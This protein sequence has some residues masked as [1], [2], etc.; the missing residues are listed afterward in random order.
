MTAGPRRGEG[1]GSVSG[2]ERQREH[3]NAILNEYDAHYGDATSCEYRQRFFLA[4]LLDGLDLNDWAVADLAAGSGHTTLGLKAMFPRIRPVGFD[5]SETAVEAYISR[6]GCPAY[7]LDLTVDN[8]PG[9]QFDAVIVVGGLHHCVNAIEVALQNVAQLLRPGGLFLMVEPSRETILEPVRRAWYGRDHY[10]EASSE[11]ALAYRELSR[12][13]NAWFE[14]M[15]VRY[16]GGV[17][18]FL[19]YNSLVFR[20]PLGLKRL[21]APSLL[22]MESLTNL[23]PG[24]VLFPY[25]VARWRRRF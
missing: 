9:P 24:K 2:G 18:Y 6:T 20:V 15:L 10:F 14:P 5:V 16:M 22:A 21:L 19:I 8:Q 7:L 25:F 11:G 12:H 3:Y 23:L 4:P 13:A 17:A 1:L